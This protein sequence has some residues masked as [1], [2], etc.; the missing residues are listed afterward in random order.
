[1]TTPPLPEK[2]DNTKPDAALDQVAVSVSAQA[3]LNLQA[4]L[5]SVTGLTQGVKS[6]PVN[7][8]AH[9]TGP[10][11][12]YNDD[13]FVGSMVHNFEYTGIQQTTKAV[14]QAADQ[15]AGTNM[16][17]KV[18]LFDK[19][20]PAAYKSPEWYGE[21]FG[22]AGG[23]FAP[24]VAA[25]AVTR[26]VSAKFGIEAALSGTAESGALLSR[27]NMILTGQTAV[28]GFASSAMFTP[29]EGAKKNF[30]DFAAERLKNGAIGG[31]D[32][33]AIT[34]GTLSLKT[35][36]TNIAKDSPVLGAVLRNS[37]VGAAISGYPTGAVSAQMHARLFEGRNASV[38]EMQQTAFSM[39][40]VGFG[41]GALHG[42]AA[43]GSV[44][45][46][47]NPTISDV[48]TGNLNKGYE[49]FDN[50][51][52]SINP[53]LNNGPRLAYAEAGGL[54]GT[55]M[56]STMG[57]LR[58]NMMMS[59]RDGDDATV[60]S[61]RGRGGTGST[62]SESTG[63]STADKAAPT[64]EVGSWSK[65]DPLHSVLRHLQLN[66]VA[67]FVEGNKVLS[68]QTV[69]RAL[70][71]GNDSPAVL[72]LA[73]SKAFPEGGALKVTIAEGGWQNNWGHRAFD[74]QLLTKAHEVDLGNS[75]EARVYVQELVDTADRYESNQVDQ[76]FAKIG[77]ANLE[78]GDQGADIMKQVGLSRK[79]GQ[80]VV[81]DYPAI[82]KEGSHETLRQL[83]E[84]HSRIEEGYAEEDAAI[85]A[86]K[87]D[88]EKLDFE[89]VIDAAR[90]G[91]RQ[92][93]LKEGAFT[94]HEQELIQQIRDGIPQKEVLEFAALLDGK[95]TAKGMPDTKAV[96]NSFDAM[97]KRAQAAG[98][99]EKPGKKAKMSAGDDES[100][101]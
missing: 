30:T 91:D 65:G 92:A 28:A 86:G 11:Q 20:L 94:P 53:L 36:G 67:D 82:D 90:E 100:D 70:G 75:G 81:I 79:T 83:T 4:E 5:A 87:N 52:A 23:Q 10:V 61:T 97:V 45:R 71:E 29:N 13:G 60:S 37:A 24:F 57:D 7:L 74:A 69:V 12:Q 98:I 54:R 48:L 42:K 2:A 34:A 1:M 19:P 96:K 17:D 3:N 43:E 18:H 93:A 56:A 33:A 51:M 80:L 88:V 101:Y 66:E 32:M 44:D 84:G 16:A 59:L 8:D 46:V 14:V 63:E 99:L 72:E 50:F 89:E 85:K 62:S 68:K 21:Q 26:G 49:H 77:N 95:L 40:V 73:P 38:A 22:T 6:K 76:L 35:V 78:F 31:V 27:N 41:L 9:S 25:F 39:S 47:N 55:A 15:L 64:R 58:S